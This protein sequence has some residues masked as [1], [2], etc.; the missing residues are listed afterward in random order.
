MKSNTNIK[1]KSSK[2]KRT[3]VLAPP[4]DGEKN[5]RLNPALPFFEPTKDPDADKDTVS[6]K[7]CIDDTISKDNKTNYKTNSFKQIKYFCYNGTLVVETLH[8][9]YLNVF[10]PYALK[11]LLLIDNYL[12]L[13]LRVIK[14]TA[15][16]QF[17]EAI[18]DYQN[19]VLGD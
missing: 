6:I 18:Q 2:S 7:M 10:M 13:F 3:K 17:E 9:I 11:S 8:A 1:V 4:T 12:R 16:T 19:R 14:V 15:K 5:S